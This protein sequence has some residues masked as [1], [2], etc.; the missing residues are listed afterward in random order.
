MFC[1]LLGISVLEAYQRAK[2]S[3]VRILGKRLAGASDND[4]AVV[5]T[6]SSVVSRVVGSRCGNHLPADHKAMLVTTLGD[7]QNVPESELAI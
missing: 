4:R 6:P 1:R 2:Y 5:V 3:A 7:P